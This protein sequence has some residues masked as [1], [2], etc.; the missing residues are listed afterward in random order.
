M[1][2]A[3]TFG[4]LLLPLL[5]LTPGCAKQGDMAGPH[6]GDALGT[7]FGERAEASPAK[8]RRSDR[9]ASPLPS[10]AGAF[11]SEAAPSE[12]D[13]WNDDADFSSGAIAIEESKPGLGTAYGEHRHS[14]VE[15]VGFRRADPS[16]PDVVFSIRYNDV[17]GVRAAASHKRTRAFSDDA[18]QQHAGLSFALL[19]DRGDVLP[20]AS[21][22]SELWAVGQPEA[23]YSLAI[24]NDTSSAFEVVTSVDGLDVIDGAPASFSKRGYIVDPFSSVVID[25]W[26]TSESSV[27]AFR[28]SSIEDSYSERMG[29]GRNVGVIGAAFFRE[30]PRQ[31][32]E[33]RAPEETWRRDRANPFPL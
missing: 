32:E 3:A 10:G 27:A 7:S 8:Q 23:R 14:S 28:F 4:L 12:A 19:D 1:Y 33:W 2:N 5:A 18:L 30:A 20:A 9:P 17:G 22:G 6:G 25:G 31:W 24:A 11:E 26:R 16:T 13:R 29:D 15:T 21:V